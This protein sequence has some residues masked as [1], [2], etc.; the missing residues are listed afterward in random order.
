MTDFPCLAE[1]LGNFQPHSY[2]PQ[3]APNRAAHG[4]LQA[5][6]LS[7][8]KS[9][10]SLLDFDDDKER[11]RLLSSPAYWLAGLPISNNP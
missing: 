1:C 2:Y 9:V 11:V 3:R 4:A 5:K 7:A 8:H 6:K 10:I